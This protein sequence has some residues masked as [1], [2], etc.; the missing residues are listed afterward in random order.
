[1][2]RNRDKTQVKPKRIKVD[3][4]ERDSKPV[5]LIQ[6]YNS[7][8]T[9][10]FVWHVR[11]GG[12]NGDILYTSDNTYVSEEDSYNFAVQEHEGRSKFDYIIERADGLLETL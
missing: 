10:G 5:R 4:V 12:R 7:V 2:A 11:E 8:D 3:D 9:N 6:I 1:M